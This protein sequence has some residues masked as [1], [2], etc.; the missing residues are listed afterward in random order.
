MTETLHANIF[1]LITSVAVV[2][3]TLLACIVLYH[4]IKIV[5]SVRRIVDRIEAGS[6]SVLDDINE[7]RESLSPT[8]I[9]S[10]LMSMVGMRT[11]RRSRS[12]RVADDEDVV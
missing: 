11:G 1:F 10:F 8:R 4:V 5:R 9:V 6:E 12:R 2:L 3:F 7:L